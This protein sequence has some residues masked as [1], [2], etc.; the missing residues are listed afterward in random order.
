MSDIVD[1]SEH[2]QARSA[3]S[4]GQS[5]RDLA[6][7]ADLASILESLLAKRTVADELCADI[8]RAAGILEVFAIDCADPRRLQSSEEIDRQWSQVEYIARQLLRHASELDSALS[9]LES[10]VFAARRAAND[11]ED[12]DEGAAA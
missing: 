12:D 10:G 1:L 9:A 3:A 7:G 6:T 8:E 11:H 2:K 5:P 4:A